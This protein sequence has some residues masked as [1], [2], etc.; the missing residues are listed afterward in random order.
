MKTSKFDSA[1]LN[2]F[3]NKNEIAELEYLNK[4]AGYLDKNI[5]DKKD[6]FNLTINQFLQNWSNTNMLIFKDLVQLFSNLGVYNKYFN[7]KE[8]SK[9]LING[10][11]A[12]LND[13]RII[14]LK[15]DRAI[16]IGIT[17]ILISIL[18]YFIGLTS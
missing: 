16:Y 8:E 6:I 17:F 14:F 5:N 13:I 1:K 4:K 10:I 7:E 18:F 12:I 9:A 11:F 15:K 2:T 3:L